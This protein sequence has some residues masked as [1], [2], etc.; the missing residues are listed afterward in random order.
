MRSGAGEG[1]DLVADARQGDPMTTSPRPA[2]HHAHGQ[3]LLLF[4]PQVPGERFEP[5]HDLLPGVGPAAG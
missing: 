1:T 3:R 4:V 2:G 5:C